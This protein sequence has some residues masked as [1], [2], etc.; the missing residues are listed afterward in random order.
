M[1]SDSAKN[2][3]NCDVTERDY[4]IF[5]YLWKWKV[6]STAALARKFFSSGDP[7]T[8]YRRFIALEK[9][10][11]LASIRLE[12][13]FHEVWTLNH[14]GFKFIREQLGELASCGYKS[15]HVNHDLLATAFHLGEWLTDQ[16]EYTQ[17]FSEQQL[18]RYPTDLWPN[19]VPRST[20]HRPDG[21]SLYFE[22]D[23][24]IVVAFETE[25]SVKSKDRY[26]SVVAFYDAEA[27]VRLVF[28]LVDTKNTIHTLRRCFEKFQMREFDKHHFILLSDFQKY[29]WRAKFAKSPLLDKSPRDFLMAQAHSRTNLEPARSSTHALLDTIKKPRKSLASVSPSART[30]AD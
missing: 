28:W 16:P 29:G 17:N 11:Y 13:R 5:R 19:W 26:Q 1:K 23:Q 25:L 4:K 9:A 6:M 3:S 24:P 27:S 30:N 8:A 12:P 10:G 15:E 22:D 7:R 2:K 21:Y 18:R 14:K 20:I